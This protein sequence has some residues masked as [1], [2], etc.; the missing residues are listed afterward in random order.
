MKARRPFQ[1][2]RRQSGDHAGVG[3][4]TVFGPPGRFQLSEMTDFQMVELQKLDDSKSE[5]L[6]P[7]E[8]GFLHLGPAKTEAKRSA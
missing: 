7:F 3:A 8:W 1:A 4:A 5:F 2:C 6:P